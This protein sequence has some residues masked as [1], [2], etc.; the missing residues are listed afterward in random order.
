[1]HKEEFK[2]LVRLAAPMVVTQLLWMSMPVVDNIMVGSL[3]GEPL[4]ALAIAGA[5]F[6]FWLM[7][8]IGVLSAVNP[9]VSQ[10]HGA[11]D[12]SLIVRTVH[13]GLFVSIL[14]A[15]MMLLGFT[16][17]KPV[18]LF[19]G[20]PSPLV[21]IAGEYLFA[22]AFGIPFQ[23]LFYCLRQF[24]DGV[25]DPKPTIILVFI[26]SVMNV[27][28]DYTFIHGHYGFPKMGVA[29][30]G[31]A[32]SIANVFL[33]LGLIAYTA[34]S[35]KYKAYYIWKDIHFSKDLFKEVFRIGLPSA[36]IFLAEVG[37][38]ASSTL[39][40]GIMGASQVASHQIALNIASVSFM[41]SMGLGFATSVRV[42]H[43]VGMGKEKDVR[44]PWSIGMWSAFIFS[45]FSA[46]LFYFGGRYL[47]L[48]Y[49][50]DETVVALGVKLLKI[51][52][53]FQIFDAIQCL[54]VQ[55]L[56]GLKDTK[57]PFLYTMISYWIVGMGVSVYCGFYLLWGPEGVWAGM[58]ISLIL[59]ALLLW[60]RFVLLSQP[61]VR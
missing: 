16:V 47:I 10:A 3:G 60:R 24:C 5:Y 9:M 19:L 27:G 13:Q 17:S 29:G 46:L 4:A 42:G 22:L 6:T 21:E 35:K 43:Y 7:T 54:G 11:K 12:Y 25:E 57:I 38:F 53:L 59:V 36:G 39:L 15:A 30:A 31:A 37:Y 55:S 32:T 40:V 26:A 14:M 33:A 48:I 44:V 56:K 50:H 49:T 1:M 51:A 61:L 23:A 2:K 52:G 8:I 41:V 18:L 34:F 28:L 58:V 45:V 20:Q